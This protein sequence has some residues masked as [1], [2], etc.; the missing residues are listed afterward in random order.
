M[1]C[2]HGEPEKKCVRCNPEKAYCSHGMRRSSCMTCNRTSQGKSSPDLWQGP[3]RGK[4]SKHGRKERSFQKHQERSSD[5][6]NPELFRLSEQVAKARKD[7][8]PLVP[9]KAEVSAEPDLIESVSKEE[10]AQFFYEKL[11]AEDI[12]VYLSGGAALSWQGGSRP[13]SDLDFRVVA[14]DLECGS[15]TE[16][17]GAAVFDYINEVVL[18]QLREKFKEAAKRL[19]KDSSANEFEAIGE[20]VI[21][22]GTPNW[23][24]VEISLSLVPWAPSETITLEG[25]DVPEVEALPLHELRNDK[26]KA[27]ISRTKRGEDSI[28]K[29]AQDLYDFLDATVLLDDGGEGH[30]LSMAEH[31][32][33][34]IS[35]RT[36]EYQVANLEGMRLDHLDEEA[37]R[38]LMRA[39]AVLTAQ[40]HLGSQG[41]GGPRKR[42]MHQL[43]E[44]APKPLKARLWKKLERL[45]VVSVLP[46]SKTRLRPW[47][48]KWNQ[49]PLQGP[50]RQ[51]MSRVSLLP[52]TQGQE[53]HVGDLLEMCPEDFL[54]DPL[55]DYLPAANVDG[56]LRGHMLQMMRVLFLSG[57]FRTLADS[58]STVQT[59]TAVGLTQNQF[60]KAYKALK[61]HKLVEGHDEGLFLSPTAK[62]LL[63]SPSEQ[64]FLRVPGEQ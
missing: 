3:S 60:D 10:I 42:M 43:I 6:I 14:S 50:Q 54:V 19:D 37:L 7:G 18:K 62:A 39:R 47:M 15:F 13:I 59:L 51:G 38:E 8:Q 48:A 2:I 23:F 22:I 20:D 52:S 29:V 36:R 27:M 56:E 12:H 45:C 28:K 4:Q 11:M 30:A 61:K 46:E 24:G 63:Y 32:E 58:K 5:E 31:L 33:A 57:G 44:S 41:K 17:Q 64:Q 21:T 49:A 25:D 16:R 35:A 9:K 26:F 40:A 55:D 1:R 53:A 34:A